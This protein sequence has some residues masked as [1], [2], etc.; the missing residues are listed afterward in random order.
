MMGEEHSLSGFLLFLLGW[1]GLADLA[2]AVAGVH[3]TPAILLAGAV[4]CAGGTLL[5][6][7]D[8]KHSLASKALGRGSHGASR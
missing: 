4:V 7:S 2:S 3:V 6:D 5:P 8:C 1:L